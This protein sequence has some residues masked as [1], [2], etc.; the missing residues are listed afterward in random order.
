[1]TPG[2][3][4]NASG[5]RKPQQQQYRE[6]DLEWDVF[7]DPKLVCQVDQAMSSVDDLN[8]MYERR[9]ACGNLHL[10]LRHLNHKGVHFSKEAVAG[11]NMSAEC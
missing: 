5:N 8:H 9:R 10:N 2:R 3:K 7:L 11:M 4:S 1:M 6:P